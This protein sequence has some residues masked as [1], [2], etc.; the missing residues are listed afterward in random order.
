MGFPT[1]ATIHRLFAA[2]FLF[3]SYRF[4]VPSNGFSPA[5]QRYSTHPAGSF[6]NGKSMTSLTRPACIDFA[7]NAPRFETS[8]GRPSSLV[9]LQES[10]RDDEYF[11]V[12]TV[13]AFVGGQSALIAVAIGVAYITKTPNFGLGPGFSFTPD[14]LLTGTLLTLPLGAFVYI[15]DLFEDSIPALK[16]VTKATHQSVLTLMGG[17]FKP[18]LGLLIAT[19]LGIVAGVGEEMLFRGILQSELASRLGPWAGVTIASL[20]FGALHAVTPAY[21]TLAGI[22]SLY[23]GGLYLACGNLA[24]PIATH[25]IYD[26][27]ALF[28]AH[29]T[30][31]R[32]TPKERTEI[33]KWKGPE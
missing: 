28:F 12:R 15:L 20:L 9:R 3:S 13:A 7:V 22:A 26:V 17:T 14:T 30:V 10:T 29:W 27:A 24:V 1:V 33:A 2:L 18:V 25:A 5:A 4:I 6:W 23:F 21:A 16:D 32:L 31:C 11:D 19:A 8:T